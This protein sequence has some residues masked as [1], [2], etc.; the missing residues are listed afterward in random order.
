MTSADGLYK[1]E[2]NM[3][4]AELDLNM[5]RKRFKYSKKKKKKR[6][7]LEGNNIG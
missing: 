2:Q 6:N 1:A 7:I 4:S 5:I 3:I